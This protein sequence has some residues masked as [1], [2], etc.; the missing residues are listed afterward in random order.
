M[1]MQHHFLNPA[2]MMYVLTPAPVVQEMDRAYLP[3]KSLLLKDKCYQ[4][5]DPPRILDL[6]LKVDMVN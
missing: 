2:T 4:K 5:I 1:C 6:L 3:D